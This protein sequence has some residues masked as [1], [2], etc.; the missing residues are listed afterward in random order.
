MVALMDVSSWLMWIFMVLFRA[1][2]MCFKCERITEMLHTKIKDAIALHLAQGICSFIT[3]QTSVSGKLNEREFISLWNK[4][5]TF[6]VKRKKKK[7]AAWN[8]EFLG[9]FIKKK[10]LIENSILKNLLSSI[11]TFSAPLM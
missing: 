9:N 5:T 3:W 11:R 1:L 2:L 10:K 6:K 7:K 4:V 8:S